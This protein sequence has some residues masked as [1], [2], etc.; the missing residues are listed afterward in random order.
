VTLTENPDVEV[1]EAEREVVI[2]RV[3]DAPARL[4]FEAYAKPEHVKRWFGPRG[5]PLTLVEMDF[6]PGGR[7]RFGMTGP[8]G[9]QNTPFGGEYLEIVPNRKIVYDNA[10]EAPGSEKMVVTI[11]YD[12]APAAPGEPHRTTMT[13]RTVFASPA[14]MH[15]YV[16]SGMVNGYNSALDQLEEVVAEMQAEWAP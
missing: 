6:R 12:E 2:R 3:F 8:D 7:F 10:F 13:I 5:W 1:T 9:T 16:G 11:T 14:M 15:E 4:L